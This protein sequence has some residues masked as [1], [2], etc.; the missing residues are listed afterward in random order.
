MNAQNKILIADNTFGAQAKIP[1]ALTY[2]NMVGYF[3]IKIMGGLDNGVYE[4]NVLLRGVR[5][6]G[7]MIMY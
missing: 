6:P 3:N 1:T 4:V 2:N 7:R 5:I